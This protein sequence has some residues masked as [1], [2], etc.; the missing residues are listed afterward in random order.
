MEK[1][2]TIGPEVVWFFGTLVAVLWGSNVYFFRSLIK[3]VED[4]DK[5]IT[6]YAVEISGL[7]ERIDKLSDLLPEVS[8]LKARLA[9]LEDRFLRWGRAEAMKSG[10]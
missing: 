7:R 8:N 3:K 2:L 1:A 6:R 4:A 5:S 9:V 10:E